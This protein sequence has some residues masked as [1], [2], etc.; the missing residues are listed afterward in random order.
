M[1][2]RLSQYTRLLDSDTIVESRHLDC[3]RSAPDLARMSV[4]TSPTPETPDVSIK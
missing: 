1:Y 2:A 4:V 3:A